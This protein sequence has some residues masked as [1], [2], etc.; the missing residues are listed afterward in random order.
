MKNYII[1]LLGFVLIGCVEPVPIE[2]PE[3][4]GF[5]VVDG[6]VSDG[7]G[8]YSVSISRT[9]KYGSVFEGRIEVI[10][11]ASVVIRDSQGNPTFLDQQV[12]N[13]PYLTP[14][15]FRGVTGETYTL[16]ITTARGERYASLPETIPEGTEIEDVELR[17]KEISGEN[18][19]SP[20]TGIEAYAKWNDPQGIQ[21]FTMWR[22]QG[23][24]FIKTFPE[25]FVQPSVGPQPKSCCAEC[26]IYEPDITGGFTIHND[27]NQDGNEIVE[28]AVFIEDN[29][30]RFNAPY[31]LRV[32]QLSLTGRAFQFY[33][34]VKTQS[35]IS[36]SI[37][38]PPPAQ[39]SGNIINLDDPNEPSLGYFGAFHS[40]SMIK[41]IDPNVVTKKQPA[42]IVND[43]CQ[44]LPG[45]SL[46]F[47]TPWD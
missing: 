7:I 14:Q 27:Q 10:N 1:L 13:G 9:S 4:L 3:D 18:V 17:F 20:I 29:G 31:Y 33:N 21:N 43:D 42:V 47:P 45:S 15:S 38:D 41:T 37:F 11:N 34:L 2:T 25:N 23:I 46:L 32:E 19:L 30:A 8:P 24:Y 5:I 22:A 39:I 40:S 36:G 16:Q 26:Y 35:E 44:V 6:Y 12:E 28:L